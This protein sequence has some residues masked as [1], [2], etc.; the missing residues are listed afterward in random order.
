MKERSAGGVIINN[1]KVVVVAQQWGTFSLPKGHI[2]GEETILEGAYRE[3]YEETGLMKE[4]LV[5]VKKLDVYERPDLKTKKPKEI[6][7][8]LFKTKVTELKPVDKDNPFAKWMDIKDVEEQ[9][10]IPEDKEFFLKI[11]YHLI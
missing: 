5:L 1:G 2:E 9:L 4:D 7:L 8:F 6:H 10:S 3:I 11:K